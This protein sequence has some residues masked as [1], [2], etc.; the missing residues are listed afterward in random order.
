VFI[1]GLLVLLAS[2]AGGGHDP[3]RENHRASDPGGH[4]GDQPR[5]ER[6][7]DRSRPS[8]SRRRERASGPALGVATKSTDCHARGQLPD[9]ACTP[10]AI[11]AATTAAQICT[12]GYSER[13]R[14]VP[15][16]R[17][18]QVYAA[19]GITSHTAGEYEIDH[20][21]PLEAGGSNRV[22]NLWPERAYSAKD[23]LENQ[24]HDDVCSGQAPLRVAQRRV[25]HNWVAVAHR[26]G[27]DTTPTAPSPPPS[28]PSPLP[29]SASP[30]PATGR[31]KDCS[32]FSTQRDAQD[33]FDHHGGTS[34]HDF[35][36]L[37]GNHDGIACSS[38]L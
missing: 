17:K 35:D 9:P 28:P 12:P 5:R 15:E 22:A 20:L 19:Y 36:R 30:P 31:D 10:G 3:D 37:D 16:S 23:Q 34:S 6:T 11:L 25:A 8:R 38:L 18:E 26:D 1:I 4:G 27:I 14:D 32:D 13:V 7:N 21:V 2:V 24:V 33:Y 29:S